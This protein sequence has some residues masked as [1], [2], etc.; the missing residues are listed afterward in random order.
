MVSL[1]TVMMP[2]ITNMIASKDKNYKNSIFISMILSI[3]IASS[4]SFGIMGVS[5]EFVPMYYGPGFEK[6]IVLYLILLPCC[7]FMAFATVIRT[8]YLLPNHRDKTLLFASISGAVVNLII[9][10]I[11]IPI[12]GSVGAAIATLVSEIVV[13][14]WQVVAVLGEL[15]IKK[16]LFY[17]IQFVILGLI[18]FVCIF[19]LNITL[20]DNIVVQVI[21]KVI[22]GAIVYIVGSI[23]IFA[24]AKKKND[25]E[26][27]DVINKIITTIS[28]KKKR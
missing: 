15:N 3:M 2:R 24:I 16:Y 11:L 10:F 4:M 12:L 19:F 1:G 25:A 6:C 26:M 13:C 5:R 7:L 23:G 18:M 28:K 17:S 21:I 20:I 22:I 27:I 9:N 8:Q 14:I